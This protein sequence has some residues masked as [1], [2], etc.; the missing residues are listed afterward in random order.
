LADRVDFG[1]LTNGYTCPTHSIDLLDNH[2]VIFVSS[3]SESSGIDSLSVPLTSLLSTKFRQPLFGGNYLEMEIVP[4]PEG[5]LTN[6]TKAEIRLKDRGLFE[7][8]S[9]LDKTRERAIEARSH[10]L[11]EEGEGLRA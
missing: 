11:G 1:S 8:A 9:A 4:S 2:K 5:S 10:R 3:A 6:G 7:F